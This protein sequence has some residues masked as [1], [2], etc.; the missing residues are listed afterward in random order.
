M[1]FLK[2]LFGG[3]SE[4]SETESVQEAGRLEHKG[5]HVIATPFK[6]GGQYQVCGVIRKHIGDELKE[7]RFIRADKFPSIEDAASITLNKGRQIIDEQGDTL[8][9]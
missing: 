5:F 2:R 1:S 3:K 4:G 9:S 7:N 8:F 6:E